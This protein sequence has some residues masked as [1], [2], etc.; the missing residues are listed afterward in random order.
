MIWNAPRAPMDASGE[1]ADALKV[2][3]LLERP[4]CV[5]KASA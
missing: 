4:E 5:S 2:K 1:E 3:L